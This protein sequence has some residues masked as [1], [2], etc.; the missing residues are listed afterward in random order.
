MAD[1]LRA[2]IAETVDPAGQGRVKVR[3][4]PMGEV[5]ES[6]ALVLRPDPTAPAPDYA[7]N[8]GVMILFLD[9]DPGTPVV[10][11]ALSSREPTLVTELPRTEANW[12]DLA[13]PAATRRGLDRL[14]ATPASG[15]VLLAGPSGTGKTMAAQILARE[16][17]RSLLAVDLSRVVSKYVGETEKNLDAVFARAEALGAVLFFDEADALFGKRTDVRDSHDRHA[18]LEAGYLLQ[19]IEAHPGLVILTTNRKQNIDPAFTRRLRATLSF[20]GPGR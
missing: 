1:P 16:L 14:V 15:M 18:N 4:Q 10:V 17:D 19:R 3:H 12:D 20:P 11:G 9:G 5:R 6:W 7:P 2:E 8:D 13:L